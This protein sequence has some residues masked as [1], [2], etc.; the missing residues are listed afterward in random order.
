VLMQNGFERIRNLS[1][2]YKTYRA[3]EDDMK[4]KI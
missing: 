2:G 4:N 1:G 3:V